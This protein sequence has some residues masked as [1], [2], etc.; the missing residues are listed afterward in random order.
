MTDRPISLPVGR[1][2]FLLGTVFSPKAAVGRLLA[3]LALGLAVGVGLISTVAPRLTLG[4]TLVALGIGGLYCVITA[5]GGRD[6]AERS[7]LGHVFLIAM[8]MRFAV[9]IFTYI[10]LPYGFFAPDESGYSYS[11]AQLG[12]SG[13]VSLADLTRSEGWLYFNAGVHNLFGS[14]GELLVRLMNCVVGAT[15]PVLCYRL[16]AQMGGAAAGRLA[17][18]LTAV[19][20]S[21]VLWSS[22]NL[23]DAEMHVLILTTLLIGLRLQ[24]GFS[25]GYVTLLGLVLLIT[26]TLRPYLVVALISSAI[27]AQLVAKR[28]IFGRLSIV[29]VVVAILLIPLALW[30]PGFSDLYLRMA[31]VD[32]VAAVRAGFGSGTQSAYMVTPYVQTPAG[33]LRFLPMGLMYFLLGPFPWSS[34]STLQLL[35]VPEMLLYYLLIPFMIVGAFR[36]LT[37]RPSAAVPVLV[38]SVMIAVSY[39]IA[40]ANFGAAYRFRAQ[41]LLVM[42]CFAAVVLSAR[43]AKSHRHR[44]AVQT[45]FETTRAKACAAFVSTSTAAGRRPDPP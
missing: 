14:G 23:K 12:I 10:T 5:V 31:S 17:A 41:L 42:L 18:C 43:T 7:F 21:L 13:L 16:T 4:V 26:S 27:V 32:N 39:A 9:A 2:A 6:A 25:V 20:P 38:F 33:V 8:A 35:T 28:H 22:L 36:A 29:V 44:G 30:L 1:G 24:K 34:G 15:V 19:F 45:S 37:T 40:V 11:G 3:L